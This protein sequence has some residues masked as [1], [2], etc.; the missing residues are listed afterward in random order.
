MSYMQ[1][2]KITKILILFFK[3]QSCKVLI[4]KTLGQKAF[5]TF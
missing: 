3:N 5:W 4:P 1:N 2:N